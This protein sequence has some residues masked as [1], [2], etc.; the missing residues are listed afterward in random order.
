[1]WGGRFQ[2]Q[3]SEL[4]KSFNDSLPI[5]YQLVKY[6]IAGSIAWAKALNSIDIINDFELIQLAKALTDIEQAVENNLDSILS[7]NAEDIHSW[8]EQALIQKVGDLGKKLHTGR[9]RNDQVLTD[10]KLWCKQAVKKLTRQLKQTHLLLNEKA[11]VF[12]DVVMPSYT[13][14]QRAQPITFGFWLNA[15]A[16]MIARDIKR[17]QSLSD[18]SD[19]CPLGASAIAGT[20]FH[21]DR[22]KLA[23]D[24][25]F[26][27]ATQ[28][29]LD[30]VSDR[31]FV[32]DLLYCSS[33]SLLHLSRLAEDLIFFN[34]Q[35][36]GFV[37]LD[38]SVTS[39]SSLMPQKKN[40]DALELIRGK[41]AEGL[42]LLSQ[43]QIATK[44][45]PLGYN[46]DLQQDKQLLFQS[47]QS[48]QQS[49]A[50]F[51]QV[52]D[53]LAVNK[54]AMRAAVENSF[55]NA[56]ELADYLVDKGIPFRDAH[57]QTGRLV[58]LAEKKQYYLHQLTLLDFKSVNN[59]IEEDIFNWLKVEQAISRRQVKG[60][61]GSHAE[62]SRSA[63]A[64]QITDATLSDIS[65]IHQLVNFWSAQGENLPRNEEDIGNQLNLFKVVKNELGEIVAC[66]SLYIYDEQ[67][68]EIRSLGVK[69]EYHGQGLG[70][71]LVFALIA[72]ARLLSLKTVFVL[73]RQPKFFSACDF[74][75]SSIETLPKKILKDCQFCP[76]K[77]SCDEIAMVYDI[78]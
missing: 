56:T 31:D 11:I 72:A 24:L 36:A 13:H 42:A 35:E 64:F 57:D 27:S 12:S 17:L 14:L 32:L 1:M 40:P 62:M 3:A 9:S 73:T 41:S 59:A 7:S 54:T 18:L 16:Q 34:S 8:V 53:T 70:K 23:I 51:N 71:R 77:A 45:L 65:T 43:M 78:G 37:L 46:K 21:I 19:E 74:E 47:V 44:S 30:T 75:Y 63:L 29:A 61:V 58:M 52:I 50:M 48:W 22:D 69:P 15:A 10:V 68:V 55:A 39:G 20:A 26:A 5:D 66:G 38:D 2:T 60:G 76:R 49:L 33:N 4:F 28:N 67:L 6:D 25:G